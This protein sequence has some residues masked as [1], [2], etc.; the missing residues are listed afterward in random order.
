M[1]READEVKR[2]VNTGNGVAKPVW[3]NANRIN[4][5]NQFVP[6]SVQLNAGRPKF[7]SVRPNINT[8]RTNINSGR[9]KVNVVSPKV[10]TVRSKQPVTHK[11]SNSSSP[12]RPQMNQMNQRR[13]FSK[14]YS[15]VRRPFANSTAQMANS[16]AEHPLK[17][18]VD[19]EIE[20]VLLLHLGLCITQK[21]QILGDPK[22]AVQTRSKVQNKSGAHA[23]LSHIQKQQRNNHKDQQHCLNK[24][25]ER[26][27][28]VR[29]KARLVAQGYT[30]E[31]GI[32]Y[33]EVFAP[34][35][36]IEAIRGISYSQPPA[37][38]LKKFDLVNVKAA[39]TP[40]E[41]KMPLTKD[42]EA[43]DVD[44]HLYRSMIGSLMYLTASRPDIMYANG[45]TFD[46][47]YSSDSDYGGSNL[48]RKSTTG[49]CQ[50]LGQ[51]LISWQCKK[52][53][54]VATSTTEA[55]Y[56]AAANCCGQVSINTGRH[57]MDVQMKGRSNEVLAF[58]NS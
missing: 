51:R 20:L 29:N 43:F 46:L 31:E 18:M 11:T 13:D 9:P 15:S 22:S 47:E 36:R 37:E 45:I 28:V 39:I 34:V 1:A 24:R 2:V 52:Q 49:G 14:S 23:L 17:N 57:S 58:V 40:M 32:D 38:I 19:R 16:N 56:V 8:G 10:N 41:T 7:N 44:V 48:D 5:A 50:F 4:H 35:A 6:R 12:K 27:V 3:T 55:E 26:G 42:E 21:V 30:Q 33:D 53:T 54:I 25:D